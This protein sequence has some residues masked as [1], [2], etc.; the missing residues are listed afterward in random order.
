MNAGLIVL[1]L[2]SGMVQTR[3]DSN[4]SL[5]GGKFWDIRLGVAL[6]RFASK[7]ENSYEFL[8]YVRC[9]TDRVKFYA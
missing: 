3:F 2:L 8:G 6:S 7:I 4:H 5:F 1:F 9:R